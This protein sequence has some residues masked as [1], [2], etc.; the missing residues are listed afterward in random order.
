M[1][2]FG[3]YS[4]ITIVLETVPACSVPWD[5]DGIGLLVLHYYTTG[6]H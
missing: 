6:Y 3:G 4:D 1:A 5:S 2:A